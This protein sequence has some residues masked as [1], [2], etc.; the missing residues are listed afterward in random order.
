MLGDTAIPAGSR[1]R[2][3]MNKAERLAHL[4]EALQFVTH[5]ARH[6]DD[7]AV[8]IEWVRQDA[9]SIV[10]ITAAVLVGLDAKDARPARSDPPGVLAAQPNGDAAG[11]TATAPPK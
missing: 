8:N 3:R 10:T 1:D 5:P 11:S 6:S 7:T 9:I 4:R 2:R